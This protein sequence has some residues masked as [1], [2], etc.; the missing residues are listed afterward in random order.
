MANLTQD[1][2]NQIFSANQRLTQVE[3]YKEQIETNKHTIDDIQ[4]HTSETI[5]DIRRNLEEEKLKSIKEFS[6]I[7]GKFTQ[8][9]HVLESLPNAV[10]RCEM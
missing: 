1:T 9:N 10:A 5:A 8:V 7:S 4:K 6:Q 2:T 3:S